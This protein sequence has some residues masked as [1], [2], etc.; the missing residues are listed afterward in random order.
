[1]QACKKY[2]VEPGFG[3]SSLCPPVHDAVIAPNRRFWGLD[4]AGKSK[5]NK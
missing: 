4:L 3:Q 1:M 5:G 2:P